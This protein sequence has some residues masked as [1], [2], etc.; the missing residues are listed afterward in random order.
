MVQHRVRGLH[1]LCSKCGCFGHIARNYATPP[2][3]TK[4]SGTI[5]S[6]D[7]NKTGGMK[8][9]VEETVTRASQSTWEAAVD[10]GSVTNQG[11]QTM[12]YGEN[13]GDQSMKEGENHGTIVKDIKCINTADGNWL[14][15]EK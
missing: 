15:M 3:K 12:K 13:H 6:K 11:D 1:L 4:D 2:V 7:A 14:I 5:A 9:T 8:P 10:V